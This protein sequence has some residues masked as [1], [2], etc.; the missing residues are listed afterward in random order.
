M[1]DAREEIVSEASAAQPGRPAHSLKPGDVA[2][3][4]RALS[5]VACYEEAL[6]EYGIDYYLVGGHAFYAQQEVFDLLNLLRAVEHPHDELSLA[7]VLRSGFFNLADETLF[8]LAQHA[9]G[10]SGGLF[11][12]RLP[13][14]RQPPAASG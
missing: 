13:A 12:D 10:L 11:A 6:R 1:F 7:G 2:I 5:D 9:Q 14:A 3:L 8:W 4:F